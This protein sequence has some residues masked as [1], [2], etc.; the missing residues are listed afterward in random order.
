[1][2]EQ[3]EGAEVAMFPIDAIYDLLV[4]HP[5]WIND[6]GDPLDYLPERESRIADFMHGVDHILE[7][8][9]AAA[10]A[11]GAQAVL[12]A[13]EAVADGWE[14]KARGLDWQSEQATTLMTCKDD[15]LALKP[16][17]R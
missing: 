6:D 12:A 13:V 11:R 5:M 17:T 2:T 16:D 1:M 8:A 10:E 9:L 14:T 7:T 15:I 4:D 3:T